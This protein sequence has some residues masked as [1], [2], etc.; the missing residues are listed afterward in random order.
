[1]AQTVYIVQQIQWEYTDEW[2][3][4]GYDEPLKAFLHRDNAE[5]H[6]RAL[7]AEARRE[8]MALDPDDGYWSRNLGATFGSFDALTS[9][10]PRALQERLREM[11]L[12]PMPSN[13]LDHPALWDAD[14]WN[15]AW[16]AVEEDA[17]R[18]EAFW[19][20]FDRLRFFEVIEAELEP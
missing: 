5:E 9:L 11:G 1:M 17:G 4:H 13:E 20:L 8:I 16:A 10:E 3:I 18:A 15:V 14:W 6:R 19:G 12:P 7:E 2:F